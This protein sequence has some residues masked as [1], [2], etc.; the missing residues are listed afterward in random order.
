MI[1]KA[2]QGLLFGA[3]STIPDII[4]R[5]LA[6]IY[7]VNLVG[8]A[9]RL[10][11]SVEIPT[12]NDFG[13]APFA[14]AERKVEQWTAGAIGGIAVKNARWMIRYRLQRAPVAPVALP[15]NPMLQLD[16]KS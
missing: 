16:G 12:I 3:L 15:A 2:V 7:D 10:D 9:S 8:R 1:S 6:P 11:F 13:G 4:Q 5:P 14:L